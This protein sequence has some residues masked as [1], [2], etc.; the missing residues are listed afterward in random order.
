M[1]AVRLRLV[2]SRSGVMILIALVLALRALIPQGMMAAPAAA[3]GMAVLLCD[4]SGAIGRIALPLGETHGKAGQAQ[5]C[6]YG[7]LA[8]AAASAALNV[9]AIVPVPL[10]PELRQQARTT[11]VFNAAP[12]LHPSA[13]APPTTA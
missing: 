1:I 8:Q 6:P 2:R 10:L 4:G 5:T 11:F 13:R 3:G 7:V 9:W 12:H